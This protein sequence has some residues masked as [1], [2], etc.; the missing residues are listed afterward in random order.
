MGHVR[1]QRSIKILED[2]LMT[3]LEDGLVPTPQE[4]QRAFDERQEQF[5]DTVRSGMRLAPMPRRYAESSALAFR[6]LL[7]AFNGDIEVMLRSLLKVTSLSIDSLGEWNLRARS[8]Q[9]RV[10]ALKSRVDSLLL[11][12]SQAAGFLSF[13]E[14]GFFSLEDVS[15]DTTANVDTEAGEVTLSIDRSYAHEDVQGTQLNLRG[16]TV[17]WSMLE[18]GN[19]RY[20]MPIPGTGISHVLDDSNNVWGVEVASLPTDSMRTA[21]QEGKPVTGEMKITL[22]VAMAFSRVVVIMSEGNSGTATVASAQYSQDG[23]TWS[24]LED[25]IPTLSGTGNFV[26]RFPL[27]E[28]KFLKFVF[29]KAAPDEEEGAGGRYVFGVQQVKLFS[30]LFE[31]EEEGKILASETRLP[32]ISGTSVP[33]GRCS[34]EV[35]EDVPPDTSIEYSL[36]AFDGTTFTP[37]ARVIP[38]NREAGPDTTTIQTPVSPI[39]DFTA[40]AIQDSDD[41]EALF[42][43][44]LE[45]GNL[46]I[47]RTEGTDTLT[48]RFDDPNLTVANFFIP[49]SDEVLSDLVFLRNVGF[50]AGKFPLVSEDLLVGEVPCGWGLDGEGTYFCEFQIKDPGG[51]QVD[52][53]ENIAFV[54]GRPL[55]GSVPIGP[56][57]HTFRTN[58]SNWL[59][60]SGSAPTTLDELK[61]ADPLYPHNHKYVIEGYTYPSTFQAEE[62]VYVGMDNYCQTRAYRIGRFELRNMDFDPSVFAL[63]VVEGPRTYILVKFDSSRPN[64]ENERVKL[65]YNRRQEDYTGVQF[66]ATLNTRDAS[67]TPVLS[68]YRIMV[69]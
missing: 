46:N 19:L 22:P 63:D 51:R 69:K 16:A 2:A 24:N 18:G 28:A 61:A 15:S 53:G 64:H 41:S 12:K 14:D 31:V 8:L 37:W 62:N 1:E 38:L 33:F 6:L 55:S 66:R 59:S 25:R 60:L 50:P 49:S 21:A 20:T 52:F 27:I 17:T 54:D 68:Y 40:P 23:Y 44:D 30:E 39:V 65:L 58:R 67:R 47:L 43:D 32:T 57:W 13:V 7:E 56:G 35:C 5:V 10:D 26:W 3:W 48:Y 4:L 29:S 36:R 42:N 45:P 9:S 34:L 11:L